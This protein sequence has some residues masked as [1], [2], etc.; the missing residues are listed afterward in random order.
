MIALTLALAAAAPVVATKSGPVR[1]A[2]LAG[3]GAVFRGIRFA[4][5]PT[6]TLRW[7]APVAPAPWR[8]P[9]PA[10]A[11]HAACPQPSYGAWNSRAAASS[12]EDCLFLDVRSP[13]LDPRAQLPVMVW[14]HGG[15]NR[16]GAGGGT[17]ESRI[18]DKGVVL[19]SVQYRLGALGFMSHPALS[20]EQGGAS[21]NY[22]LMDQ[23]AALRWVRENIVNFGGDPARVTIAGES[24]GAQ[25]VGLQMLS[26]AARGLF[27]GAIAQSGTPG[28]GVAPRTLAQ[29]EQLGIAIVAR[30]GA[31]GAV[32][33]AALRD[34]P[35][36]SVLA[37]QEAVDVPGLDDDSF[38]WLQAVVDG[39]VLRETPAA[40]LAAG[41]VARV[42]LLIGAN[43]QE[44]TNYTGRDPGPVVAREFPRNARAVRR[45]YGL[46]GTPAPDPR[47]GDV[48]M[49]LGTDLVFTCPTVAVSR[50]VAATGAPVWQYQFDY[51]P[52]GK[53]VSHGSEMGLVFDTPSAGAPRL[54]DYWVA[55]VK[56][57]DPNGSGLST[58]PRYDAGERRYLAFEQGG[59]VSRA[60]L[61]DDVCL[62]RPTP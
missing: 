23:R 7:R 21:G 18:T 62:Q 60:R 49:R 54:R 20:A 17:V 30:A 26:P 53:V 32:A 28:F 15:G 40:A 12:S 38:I 31:K 27:A 5:P 50:Q 33:A 56:R 47:R 41:R 48:A 16:G 34:L 36:A 14:I 6:G 22:G 43:A 51:A 57:G 25:D 10:N 55:F 13:R 35:V 61:R 44:F 59:T 42:P 3:G 9:A 19:V 37:A 58:W 8:T 2:A 1:G 24:A 29:N 4:A 46:D 39:R 52:A 11:A 45:A